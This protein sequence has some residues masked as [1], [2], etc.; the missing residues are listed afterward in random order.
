M[1][2]SRVSG[3]ATRRKRIFKHLA[4]FSSRFVHY[5]SPIRMRIVLK[6]NNDCGPKKNSL[7][8]MRAELPPISRLA[9]FICIRLE[10]AVPCIAGLHCGAA[11]K[12]M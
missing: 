1:Y 7:H 5:A 10:L 11:I 4:S 9:L 6:C 3:F 12:R 2:H 8:C